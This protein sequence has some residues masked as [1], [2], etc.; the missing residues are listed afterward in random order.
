MDAEAADSR[1]PISLPARHT[2]RVAGAI[3]RAAAVAGAA[4]A[5]ST[6]APMLNVPMLAARPAL[7]Q[8]APPPAPAG[9]PAT[10]APA[11]D[12][13]TQKIP[14]LMLRELMPDKPP[15]LSL[16]DLPSPD[17]GA[18]GAK[19][20][21]MDN[22][23]TGRFMGQEFSVDVVDDAKAE[24]L[25]AEAVKRVDG[26]IGFVVVDGSPKTIL[27]V[28]DALKGKNALVIN[29]S[30]PDDSIREQDCRANLRH[31]PPT[32]T[33]LADALAQYLVWKRW[34]KWFLVLGPQ[35]EDQL[36]ADAYRRAAKKFGAKIVDERTFK[37]EGGSRR[38]DGGYEQV[39]QQI[40][41]FTQ[42]AQPHD[43]VMVADEGGLFGDYL[44]YRTWDARPVAG[45]AGLYATSWH[46]ALELWG[47]TQFQNRFKRLTG[48]I[49]K[50]IDYTAWLAVRAVGEAA[51]RKK[52]ADP[53][54]LIPYMGS[55]EFELAAFKGIKTTFRA[56]NGQ[57]RQPILVATPKLPVSV[58]P[59]P[60]F[61]HQVT[62]LDTLGIDKPETKCKAFTP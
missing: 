49:M 18:A 6:L 38:S 5:V 26:G 40:P 30:S 29:A 47:G 42:G 54:V 60:G 50:P 12:A 34:L 17:D 35:P 16:L 44:P 8:A 3:A 28:A 31:T 46:A 22:N 4:C 7:A 55:P 45:T 9:A 33:M 1:R 36:M 37:A 21:V 56:W 2:S 32:R 13:T 14:I 61:L 11:A 57:L 15:P 20:A 52:S 59:Q 25:V 53:K 10:A 51:A 39:Q 27:A 58:S 41:T 62:E 23:T 43:I 24:A 19:L 48:R